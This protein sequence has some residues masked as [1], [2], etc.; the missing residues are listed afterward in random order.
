MPRTAKLIEWVGK[1]D[2]HRAPGTVRD[3]LK[4]GE[5]VGRWETLSEGPRSAS[6]K[7]RWL[8]RCECGTVRLVLATHLLNERTLAC[9][10]CRPTKSATVHGHPLYR[11]YC[12]IIQRCENPN[13]VAYENYGARGIAMHP[14]WR[15]DFWQFVKDMGARPSPKHTVERVNNDLGYGPGN[16]VWAPR[17]VQM[18]NTRRT[19]FVMYQGRRMSLVDACSMSGVKYGTA[20]WRLRNGIPEERAFDAS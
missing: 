10:K 11:T 4:A 6:D 5:R 3:R 13:N 2:D 17:A 14:A 19:H 1:S 15:A 9:G 16:C 8:C 12:N 18:R 20:K 7:P